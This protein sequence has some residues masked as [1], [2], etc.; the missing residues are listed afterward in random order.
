VIFLKDKIMLL[1]YMLN[2]L[3]GGYDLYR[4]AVYN[5][6]RRAVIIK[7]K[8]DT[9]SIDLADY[10][11]DPSPG[12]ILVAIDNA[13]R[14]MFTRNLTR[15]SEK[16]ISLGLKSIFK[17]AGS[18]PIWM[19]SDLEKGFVYSKLLKDE[20]VELYHTSFMGSPLVE[21]AIRSLREI[22]EKLRQ[23]QPAK[24]WKTVVD[25]ATVIYNTRVHSGIKQTPNHAWEHPEVVEA[26]NKAHSLE[27]RKAPKVK[28]EIGDHV[29][30][31][32]EKNKFD[33]G[34]KKRWNS[35]PHT[36]VAI[37]ERQLPK[38]Y[39][40]NNGRKYYVQELQKI[41][42]KEFDELSKKKK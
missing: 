42:Q 9:W 32:F 19:H 6:P 13:T 21:R 18:S 22:V 41:T 40:V 38:M 28:L 26:I 14:K 11:K 34:F 7:E 30:T 27:E 4:R 8:N 33:K 10:S 36:I 23:T 17:E 25:K 5:F 12:Y 3:F 16:E 20:G 1:Y 29:L 39:I 31:V 35:D 2:Y 15:K 37:D 24:Q